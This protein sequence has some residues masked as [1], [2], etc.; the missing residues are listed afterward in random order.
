MNLYLILTLTILKNTVVM[1]LQKNF[2]KELFTL[3]N[4]KWELIAL[5]QQLC[6]QMS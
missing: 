3:L 1:N 4:K 6:M 5:Y 2:T